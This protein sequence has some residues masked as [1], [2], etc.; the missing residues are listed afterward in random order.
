LQEHRA[1]ADLAGIAALLVETAAPR[2][3]EI[4]AAY[5]RAA[6][7]G[8]AGER[9][10]PLLAALAACDHTHLGPAAAAVMKTGETSGADMLAGFVAGMGAI[11][12]GS[13]L[14]WLGA[15]SA[16]PSRAGHPPA[17]TL[18]PTA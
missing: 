11:H 1:D 3:H 5:L 6:H 2:T 8:E 15:P 10:H 17:E 16:A 14:A 13:P 4:S 9:W 12:A 18:P 7:A